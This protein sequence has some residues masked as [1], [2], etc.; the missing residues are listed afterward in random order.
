MASPVTKSTVERAL[1][2][3]AAAGACVGRS[4]Y[5]P[6]SAPHSRAGTTPNA[7]VVANFTYVKLVA[8]VSAYVAFAIDA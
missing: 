7:L 5:V 3:A 8:G 2:A 1:C 4:R 6:R